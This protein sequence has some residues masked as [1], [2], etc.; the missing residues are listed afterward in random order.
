MGCIGV[1][2]EDFVCVGCG[3]LGGVARGEGECEWVGES[4][5]SGEGD[6]NEVKEEE[7]VITVQAVGAGE[8]GV[9]VGYLCWRGVEGVGAGEGGGHNVG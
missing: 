4:A 3:G 2:D 7:D 6:P 5:G 8:V 1:V 9:G